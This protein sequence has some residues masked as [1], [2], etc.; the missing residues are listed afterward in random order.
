ML[1]K[2]EAVREMLLRKVPA[3][4]DLAETVVEVTL[5]KVPAVKDLAETVVEVTLSQWS[6]QKQTAFPG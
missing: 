4:K 5:R 6:L 3:V 2:Q 1:R